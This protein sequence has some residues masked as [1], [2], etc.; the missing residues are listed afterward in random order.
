MISDC[1]QRISLLLKFRPPF[2]SRSHSMI[3]K[4]IYHTHRGRIVMNWTE[5]SLARYWRRKGWHEDAA[6]Q[7]AY[8]AKARSHRLLR[9]LS[10]APKMPFFVANYVS[11]DP[12]QKQQQPA[13]LS[14]PSITGKKMVQERL[15]PLSGRESG[16]A[17]A[18]DSASV[19]RQNASMQRRDLMSPELWAQRD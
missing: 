8:F 16:A 9:A 18:N 19:F 3:L 17:K 11:R 6:R 12:G 14:P 10:S 1:R 13:T 15:L 5:R 4:F 7:K 2:F